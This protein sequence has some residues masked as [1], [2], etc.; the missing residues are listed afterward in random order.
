MD[1]Q[2][3]KAELMESVGAIPFLD[4]KHFASRIFFPEVKY[5]Y[6]TISSLLNIK[7]TARLTELS[8]NFQSEALMS[9]CIKDIGQVRFSTAVVVCVRSG[10]GSV[11]HCVVVCDL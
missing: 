1:L 3:E 2:T 8:F 9:L 7:T 6:L 4:Y 11:M 5:S 10:D